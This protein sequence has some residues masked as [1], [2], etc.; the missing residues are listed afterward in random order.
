MNTGPE[1]KEPTLVVTRVFDAPP[2]LVFK[3]WTDPKHVLNWWGPKN[4]TCPFC[5]IDLRPDGVFRFCMRSPDGQDYWNRGVYDEIVPPPGRSRIASRIYFSDAAGNIVPP[6]Y[7]G[8][9]TDIPAEMRDVVTFEPHGDE[10]NPQTRLT[11]RRDTPLSVSK[12]Y[13]EDVGWNQSLDRFEA[14][15]ARARSERE[16]S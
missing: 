14:E 2:D 10:R 9:G 15:L 13:G 1:S 5:T 11:I 6:T 16:R 7:Y 4:F 8:L 3:V 12:R